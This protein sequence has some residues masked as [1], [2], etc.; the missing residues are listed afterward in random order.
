MPPLFQTPALRGEEKTSRPFPEMPEV[1]YYEGFET[2]AVTW[3]VGKVD[4]ATVQGPGNAHSFKLGETKKDNDKWWSGSTDLPVRFPAGMDP[5]EIHI[6]FMLW[7][8]EMGEI[9]IKF[10]DG[11]FSEKAHSMKVKAW[12]PVLLRLCDLTKDKKH[13]TKDA[14]FRNVEVSF[15]PRDKNKTPNV[16]IDDFIISCG[17]RP[18]D[19]L[20][21]LATLESGHAALIRSAAQDGF[22]F[23]PQIKEALQ[24]A[25]KHQTGSRKPKTV[26][27]VG[28]R[29][30][31]TNELVKG[32]EAD[33]AREKAAGFNFVPA[34]AP[35]GFPLGG[36]DDMRTLLSYNI[37]KTEA[38]VAL[39]ML[40][41]A[42]TLAR[43]RPGDSTKVVLERILEAGCVP[44]LCLPPAPQKND[45]GKPD[46]FTSSVSN[47][48]LEL[49]VPWVDEG[50][51][52]KNLKNAMDKQDLST[53]GVEALAGLAMQAIKHVDASVFPRK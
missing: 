9:G 44:I 25:L 42:D 49:G 47:V 53:A 35:N 31:D 16:F 8:D 23:S 37:Q 3:K 13:V 45:K 17:A 28:A 43:G 12:C 10:K 48:C 34:A 32:L 14:S 52:I 15:R 29:S 2:S 30:S 41:H 18:A 27:V 21:R 46:A 4:T 26:L 39:L 38:G 6:Q 51:C 50:F 5:N 36:L 20:P 7:T 11:D 1:L 24:S 19:L 40:G 33:A 22:T